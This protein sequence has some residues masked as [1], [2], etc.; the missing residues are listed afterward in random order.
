MTDPKN[1]HLLLPNSF[2]L[3]LDQKDLA[4]LRAITRRAAGQHHLTDYEC[5]MLIEEYGTE[6]AVEEVLRKTTIVSQYH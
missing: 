4:R 6:T 1:N 2:V 5:D 3:N